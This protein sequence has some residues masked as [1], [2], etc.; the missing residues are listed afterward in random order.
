MS[1][2]EYWTEHSGNFPT[3]LWQPVENA[4]VFIILAHVFR[5]FSWFNI[6]STTQTAAYILSLKIRGKKRIKILGYTFYSLLLNK[7]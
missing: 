2:K 7:L 6:K 4:L 1:A 3:P 5:L